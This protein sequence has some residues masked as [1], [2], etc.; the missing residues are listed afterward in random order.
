L[1]DQTQHT[2]DP[3]P[4]VLAL[5]ALERW[6]QDQSA[7]SR[8]EVASSLEG[9][10]AISG[11]LGAVLQVNAPPLPAL[12]VSTGSLSVVPA[13]G[14]RD[15][16]AAFDLGSHSGHQTLGRL[17]L[18]APDGDVDAVVRTVELAVDAA[19]SRAEVHGRA[20]RLAA[21]EKATRAVAAELDIDRVLGVI[22]DRV[23]E[24]VGAHVAAMGIAAMRS[25]SHWRTSPIWSTSR[26][27]V[28]RRWPAST[29]R[30]TR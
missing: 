4:L 11:A 19:W 20:E 3:Y 26:T 14:E 13:E 5:E 8:D 17:F 12:E 28:S 7:D 22:V 29:A 15:G 23:R 10:V 18:D 24:R 1:A 6:R 9:I 27:A 25:A 16:L 2:T 30:S 21:L